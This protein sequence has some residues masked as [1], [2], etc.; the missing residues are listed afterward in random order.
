MISN[1]NGISRRNE[2]Q[3]GKEYGKGA[4]AIGE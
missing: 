1:R 2:E 3:R 4:K